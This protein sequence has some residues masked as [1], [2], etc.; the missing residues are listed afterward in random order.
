[1]VRAT[2][3]RGSLR[4]GSYEPEGVPASPLSD[5]SPRRLSRDACGEELFEYEEGEP[6]QMNWNLEHV[7]WSFLVSTIGAYV[8]L[9]SAMI[10]VKS[11]RGSHWYW[12]L[13]AQA[14]CS[15]GVTSVWSMHFIGMYALEL[16]SPGKPMVE[17]QFEPVLTIISGLAAWLIVCI[18]LHLI[19]GQD[20]FGDRRTLEKRLQG[21]S[22]CSK[23]G[24]LLRRLP[25]KR[26]TMASVLVSVGVVVMHYMGMLSQTGHFW[27]E[28]SAGN[29]LGSMVV[30]GVASWIALPIFVISFDSMVFRFGASFGIGVFVNSMHYTGM[31]AAT[32]YYSSNRGG[33][34]GADTM[35][36]S[37]KSTDVVIFTL[38]LDLVLMGFTGYYVELAREL[39]KKEERD[40]ERKLAFE[41]HKNNVK[42]LI[43]ESRIMSYPMC[44]M[45][46]DT[47]SKLGKLVPHEQLRD[48]H[49]LVYLN[50]VRSVLRLKRRKYYIIFFSHQ[51]LSRML[52]DP[53]NDHYIDMMSALQG[54]AQMF[55]VRLDSLYIFV[56]YS[57]IPQQGQR[58]QKLAIDSLAT[59]VSLSSAFVIVSPQTVH[60][61]S[62][63]LCNFDTYSKRFWCRLEVFCTILASLREKELKAV[64][65]GQILE[66]D[67][68]QL[69]ESAKVAEDE[70]QQVA[71]K[72]SELTQQQRV[73]V[74]VKNSLHALNFF[75]PAGELQPRYHD[76][77]RLFEG[78]TTCCDQGHQEGDEQL[79]DKC[80]VIDSLTG[81]YGALLQ[82]LR[83]AKRNQSRGIVSQVPSETLRLVEEIVRQRADIFPSK[84]FE[85]RIDAVHAR[86]D[87]GL[88][89][90][91][92]GDGDERMA[93][94]REDDEDRR[95]VD[96]TDDSSDTSSH[97]SSEQ[98]SAGLSNGL[99]RQESESGRE[100]VNEV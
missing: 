26:L 73:F 78:Q 62:S 64:E 81:A 21:L 43:A 4:A 7:G 100:S 40:V 96:Y 71:S 8:A 87:R 20:H 61:D 51:W 42:S 85:T 79:C 22:S 2:L 12:V 53:A 28:F 25:L 90:G 97:A 80:R 19:L 6:I 50:T 66:E 72:M 10:D 35:S 57:S 70:T 75:T 84:Y 41:S 59:Y 39:V 14:G 13:L 18:A 16:K 47:F 74:V 86:L 29:I 95:S 76:L 52:P 36:I 1:V 45:R 15:L 46:Y 49:K 3:A 54:L 11:V 34:F 27:M 5:A 58:V 37:L 60:R 63:A 56:D 38:I 67:E 23:A 99:L 69:E 65:A 17:I 98:S 44:L 94:A 48:T 77:L 82:D 92:S 88:V 91:G 30:A 9:T 55:K 89:T 33:V 68:A 93:T 83:K 24:W 32:Y 31:T